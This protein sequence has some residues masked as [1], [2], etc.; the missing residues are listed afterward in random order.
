MKYKLIATLD[1]FKPRKWK[2]LKKLV[3]F[4]ESKN[5][6]EYMTKRCAVKDGYTIDTEDDTDDEI[7]NTG[8]YRMTYRDMMCSEVFLYERV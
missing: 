4:G 1:E 6:I 7:F 3:E 8:V 2:T 5:V